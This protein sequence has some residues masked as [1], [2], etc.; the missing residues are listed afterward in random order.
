MVLSCGCAFHRIRTVERLT[1]ITAIDTLSRSMA[2][3]DPTS[4]KTGEEG[5]GRHR[6]SAVIVVCLSACGL[7]ALVASAVR[8][9]AIFSVEDFASGGGEHPGDGGVTA[10]GGSDGDGAADAGCVADADHGSDPLNCGSCGHSCLGGSCKDG[11]CEAFALASGKGCPTGI[12]VYDDEVYW[13]EW[14]VP[15][16][17]SSGR[18][19]RVLLSTR[20]VTV[21][22]ETATIPA[23]I[24]VDQNAVYWSE[25][26]TKIEPD[27]G[28][29]DGHIWKIARNQVGEPGDAGAP[30]ALRFGDHTLGTLALS[31]TDVYYT[32]YHVLNRVSKDGTGWAEV[33]PYLAQAGGVAADQ[34]GAFFTDV[35]DAS[36][37]SLRGGDASL[38]VSGSDMSPLGLAVDSHSVYWT[39][40]F[41]SGGDAGIQVMMA[42]KFFPGDASVLAQNQ[43][44]PLAI[45]VDGT[46]VYWTNLQNSMI[47]RVLKTGG[48]AET[49][50]AG[51][52]PKSIAVDTKGIY[53]ADCG[54]GSVMALAK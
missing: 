54:S 34:T 53:W 9:T 21:M 35:Q 45:A 29:W 10:E 33:S 12:A 13:T 41:P 11:R 44:G 27:S 17:P 24:A 51:N 30:A 50:A 28:F 49:V 39:N 18:I 1:R 22:A 6:V 20:E 19:G 36:V 23:Q 2:E 4:A 8:C 3:C 38:L 47:M 32:G 48:T 15:N 43:Q 46:H 26:S 14:D 31:S 25:N 16:V 40:A 7:L 37:W 52:D 5:R 42:D